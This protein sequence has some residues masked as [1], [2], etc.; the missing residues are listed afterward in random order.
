FNAWSRPHTVSAVVQ[1]RAPRELRSGW[2]SRS[3]LWAG[4]QLASGTSYLSC[5]APFG[6]A[7]ILSDQACPSFGVVG[8]LASMYTRLPARKVLDLRFTKALSDAPY[9]PRFFIDARN[10]LNFTTVIRSY[11]DAALL[12]PARSQIIENGVEIIQ[13]EASNNGAYDAST[14]AVNLS[15]PGTCASWITFQGS[16]GAPDCVAL[17]RAEARYGNG[18]GIYS[19]DE[20]RT[21]VGAAFDA[22]H[23]GGLNGTPRRVRVGIEMGI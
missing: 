3:E 11:R 18:D 5:P 23:L 20:Q 19:A 10:L 22:T 16:G 17:L 12:A 15:A 7:L 1:F 6:P 13:V 14:G 21:A 4:F 9:A 2:L 8:G